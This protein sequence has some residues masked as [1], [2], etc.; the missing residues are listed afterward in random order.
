MAG[1]F[2]PEHEKELIRRAQAGDHQAR[3]EII[4]LHEGTIQTHMRRHPMRNVPESS[5]RMHAIRLVHRAIDTYDPKAGTQPSSWIN[6]YLQK[7]SRPQEE[8]HGPVRMPTIGHLVVPFQMVQR[9]LRLELGRHPTPAEIQEG[10]SR[11]QGKQVPLRHVQRLMTG[12][13]TEESA[14]RP[15]GDDDEGEDAEAPDQPG[16]ALP[17]VAERAGEEEQREEW[18]R[19]VRALPA[20]Q[21][22]V[23][24]HSL[25]LFGK[26]KM[27]ERDMALNFGMSSYEVRKH[28]DGARS[29][30]RVHYEGMGGARH[31]S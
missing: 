17:D 5:A 23:L 27:S 29:A 10:L 21:R 28:L 3:A 20:A 6:T 7:M 2:D 11:L 12:V 24:S 19:R 18:L 8:S 25:G 4:R 26:K 30:L 1:R 15:V 22:L 9:Q 14:E 13:F 31:E 16:H